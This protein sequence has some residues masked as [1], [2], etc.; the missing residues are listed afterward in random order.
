M[1]HRMRKFTLIELLVV[2]AII[3]ILASI[4]LPALSKAKERVYTLSCLNHLKQLGLAEVQYN[5]DYDDWYTPGWM[6]ADLLNRYIG[7]NPKFLQQAPGGTYKYDS[8]GY[9]FKCTKVKGTYGI[10]QNSTGGGYVREITCLDYSRNTALHGYALPDPFESNKNMRWRKTNHLVHSPS[11]VL[12]MADGQGS[13]RID[14]SQW[15]MTYGP[16]LRH[17]FKRSVNMIFADSHGVNWVPSSPDGTYMY[18]L[19]T[20]DFFEWY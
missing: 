14:Y 19:T 8:E 11:K 9:P 17:G 1:L 6:Y 12:N 5:N 4:L 18:S 20:H 7:V 3:A 16:R 15:G 10:P 2:I 13:I